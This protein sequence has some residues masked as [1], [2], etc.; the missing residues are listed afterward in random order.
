MSQISHRHRNTAHASPAPHGPTR[1]RTP[2]ESGMTMDLRTT[3]TSTALLRHANGVDTLETNSLCCAA[4]GIIAPLRVTAEALV[5]HEKLR[6]AAAP[7]ATLIAQHR[8]PAQP[9]QGYKRP[10]LEAA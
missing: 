2:E 8:P 3:P 9:V 4:A 1:Y 5:P 7:N 6:E 10:S